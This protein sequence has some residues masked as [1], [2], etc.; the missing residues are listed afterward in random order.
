[1]PR[2][3]EVRRGPRLAALAV[4]ACTVAAGLVAALPASITAEATPAGGVVLD[5]YG[6][7]HP[8]G[9][10]TLDTQGSQ[11]WP[12]WNIARALNIR[13]DGSG[14][15]DLDGYGGIH[16][17]GSAA[18]VASPVYWRGWDIA[19]SLTMTSVGP[20]GLPD[21]RQGY[22]MDG[23]GG[24]HPWGGA[25]DLSGGPYWPGQDRARGLAVH[26]RGDGVPDGGWVLD[27]AGQVSAFGGA[28]A[29][30]VPG[31]AGGPVW[32]Q[33]HVVAGGA[34]P[35]GYLVSR[36]GV[37]APFGAGVAPSWSGYRD[38]G[39]WGIVADLVMAG[40]AAGDGST[41]GS[42]PVAPQPVSAAAM[43][44]FQA[45]VRSVRGG[46]VL[47]GF[48]GLHP[49]G[50]M[51]LNNDRASYWPGWDIARALILRADGSGGWQL[52]GLGGLHAFGAAPTVP[53]HSSWPD[54]DIARAAAVTSYG[55]DGLAD[56]RQGYLLDGFG[57]L[58]PWGGA[59]ALSG[60]PYWPGQDRARGFE[61][62]FGADG[63][64]DGG[65]VLDVDGGVWPFGGAASAD[66]APP[67]ATTATGS[68]GAGSAGGAAGR[69]PLFGRPLW[70]QLHASEAGFVAVG[71]WVTRDLGD[72][73]SPWW[74]GYGDFG[75]WD[76]TRDIVLGDPSRPTSIP[77]PVSPAAGAAFGSAAYDLSPYRGLSSWEDVFAWSR[78][79]TGG[80]PTFGLDDVDR[81]AAAGVQTLFI[82]AARWDSPSGQDLVD[83]DLLRSIVRRAHQDGI[84]VVPW[85]LPT[86]VDPQLDLRRLMA[87]AD[88]GEGIAVDIEARN[89]S[90]VAERNRRLVDLSQALRRSLPGR[91]IGG[92][93][94]PPVVTEVVN[95]NYWPGFPWQGLAPLYDVWLP[96]SYWTNRLAS[97][98]YR[99]AYRY[100]AEDIIRLRKDLGLPGAVV[101]T[102]GG[103]AGATSAADVDGM[104]RAVNDTGA[105][106]G[107]LY[108]WATTPPSVLPNLR[109]LR[110]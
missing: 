27:T 66:G 32:R 15:W 75:S 76:I 46:V 37:I 105:I 1:M 67:G 5:G 106:G 41:P 102:I 31:L 35:S 3:P 86:L 61:P 62:H 69:T 72:I 104:V 95:P 83:P 24:L 84:Q 56:G 50:G 12:G 85:Y 16:A 9:G 49:F 109:A 25:P 33:L 43:R 51:K 10:L 71:R 101:D 44:S 89:V 92:I 20:D 65:W 21:G 87:I 2:S 64:P 11:S 91:A 4:V 93:A 74:D 94:L 97:S 39:A 80:Q 70:R 99:D 59:P 79:Y 26:L 13:A 78:S 19:R 29:I 68:A 57:G 48:G 82:Q 103:L 73:G 40:G 8:F 110:R 55:S 36:W 81:M 96:M 28:P 54:W 52:D 38:F 107:G 42:T 90:D 23:F 7:L 14:G 60:A 98:G 58:H 77:E 18:P 45:A 53:E 17:F 47:D 22:L 6:G 88:L 34:A 30:A 108:D 63:L 100:T